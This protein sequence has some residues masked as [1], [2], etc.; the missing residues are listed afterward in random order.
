MTLA[1]TARK[2]AGSAKPQASNSKPGMAQSRN[3]MTRLVM[4]WH[5]R[6]ANPG[7]VNERYHQKAL[8]PPLAS[9]GGICRL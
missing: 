4:T 7:K 9:A 6:K 2:C 8:L 1:S 5:E 3:P